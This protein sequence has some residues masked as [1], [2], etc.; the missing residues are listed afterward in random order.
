[1]S[2]I[3]E[4]TVGVPPLNRLNR[5]TF[6]DNVFKAGEHT[7]SKP[8][9]DL[10]QAAMDATRARIGLRAYLRDG[11]EVSCPLCQEERNHWCKLQEE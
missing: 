5:W 2:K 4:I 8:A 7:I 3:L 1:M 10:V 6:G 11:K 9:K